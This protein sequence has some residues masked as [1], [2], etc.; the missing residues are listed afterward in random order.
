MIHVITCT[1][2]RR[3]PP[4]P[5]HW[6]TETGISSI[7]LRL[8]HAIPMVV[9]TPGPLPLW[10]RRSSSRDED[11][12]GVCV[13]QLS[14]LFKL[15][16]P[17]WQPLPGVVETQG[18]FLIPQPHTPVDLE[19]DSD[20]AEKLRMKLESAQLVHGWRVNDY[21]RAAAEEWPHRHTPP[22]VRQEYSDRM[23]ALRAKREAYVSPDDGSDGPAPWS[24]LGSV[25]HDS[26]VSHRKGLFQITPPKVDKDKWIYPGIWYGWEEGPEESKPQKTW[27][28]EMF[29]PEFPRLPKRRLSEMSKGDDAA[30][31]DADDESRPRRR[32]KRE[33][34][35]KNVRSVSTPQRERDAGL[36][37][38]YH[39]S[40]DSPE[41]FRP[42]RSARLKSIN[43]PPCSDSTPDRTFSHWE[44]AALVNHGHATGNTQDGFRPRRSARLKSINKS[45]RHGT[46]RPPRA[47]SGRRRRANIA[48]PLDAG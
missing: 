12:H 13:L 14:R 3:H 30:T 11:V 2:L 6:P 10:I 22:H 37:G 46:Q 9:T 44:R 39:S 32:R 42:R 21:G 24:P 34:T 45:S 43:S 26:P 4:S 38:V 16:I 29:E 40:E 5:P 15:L 41:Q 35:L 19:P 33:A 28:S 47:R 36:A 31:G 1:D 25:M 27:P 48:R 20:F 7:N 18:R 8:L 23:K 17:L